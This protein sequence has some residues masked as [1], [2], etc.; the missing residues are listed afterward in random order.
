MKKLF[1]GVMALTLAVGASAFTT[2]SDISKT[3]A[4]VIYHNIG[5]NTYALGE[6]TCATTD[7]NPCLYVFPNPSNNTAPSTFTLSSVPT[8]LGTGA[9]EGA[10]RRL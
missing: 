4:E 1:F 3:R 8:N 9:Q 7:P 5:S 10:L 2:G 6:A